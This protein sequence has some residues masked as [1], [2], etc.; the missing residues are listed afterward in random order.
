MPFNGMSTNIK[1]RKR[2]KATINTSNRG[3]RLQTTIQSLYTASSIYTKAST[4][5]MYC[6]TALHISNKS[7]GM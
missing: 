5:G 2:T 1:V 7:E 4:K 6:I 3:T